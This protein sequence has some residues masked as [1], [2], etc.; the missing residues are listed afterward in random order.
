MSVETVTGRENENETDPEI[1]TERETDTAIEKEDD[2]F[3][4]DETRT[5][6]IIHETLGTTWN[7]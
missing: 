6:I 5:M 2:P 4:R 7:H 3:H 1:E